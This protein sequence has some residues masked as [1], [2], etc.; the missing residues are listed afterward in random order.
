MG[1]LVDRGTES[2]QVLAWLEK[3]WFHAILGNHD[4][5]AFRSALGTPTEF[6]YLQSWGEWLA[7]LSEAEQRRIGEGLAALPLAM[8]IET[9]AGIVGLVHADCPFDDWLDMRKVRG[10][11]IDLTGP[12]AD[13][14]LWSLERH[15]RRYAGII[16]NIR[17]VVH[18]HMVVR[19]PEVLGNVHFIDTGGWMQGGYFTFLELETLK[20]VLGP[21]A[22]D[23]TPNRKN[24]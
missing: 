13:W 20:P 17:A 1:D 7:R 4:F 11:G 14:C 5:M 12:I 6:D 19:T 21:K 9:A 24:R 23:K 22:T 15:S 10:Q 8:E 2:D 18:G 3:P 16:R